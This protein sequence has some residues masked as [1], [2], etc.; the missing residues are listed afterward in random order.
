MLKKWAVIIVIIGLL[1]VGCIV[2]GNYVNSTFDQMTKSLEKYQ[3]ML[4]NTDENIDIAENIDYLEFL[5]ADFHEKEKVLKALIW[6]TGLKD[7]EVGLSRIITY[8]KE[9]DYTEAMAETKALTDYCKHYS[10]DFKI[11]PE[12]VF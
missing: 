9:K 4:E 12:N 10:L 1:V 2:E 7:V 5:H 11:T 3:T 8:T 6:H